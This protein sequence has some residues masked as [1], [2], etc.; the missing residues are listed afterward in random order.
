MKIFVKVKSNAKEERV[1]Q[2]SDKNCL[3]SVKAE[4]I[5]GKA[6]KALVK[7]LARYFGTAPSAIKI[8]RGSSSRHKTV[9]IPAIF[10]DSA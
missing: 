4:P 6:N 9:N 8:V 10:G 2:V 5:D 3:V 7:L 1:V